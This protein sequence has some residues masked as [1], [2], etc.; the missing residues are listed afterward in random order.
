MDNFEKEVDALNLRQD[1]FLLGYVEDEILQWLY[2]NCFA[3]IYPSLFEGFGLPVLEAM[4]LGAP[5][6][7]SN[8]SSLPEIAG[9]AALFI[10]PTSEEAVFQAMRQLTSDPQARLLFKENSTRQASQFSWRSTA[11]FLLECY[12]D[13][14]SRDPI[15]SRP[16]AE[17]AP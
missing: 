16:S 14:S 15:F 6:I 9:Q 3:F 7:T 4:S 12:R 11:S 2:Q 17:G 10:D 8:V 1:V 13:L 5:V